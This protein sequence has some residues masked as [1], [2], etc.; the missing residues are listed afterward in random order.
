[1]EKSSNINKLR[2]D[3]LMRISVFLLYYIMMLVLTF[4]LLLLVIGA[5]ILVIFNIEIFLNRIGLVLIALLVASWSFVVKIGFGLL[6]SPFIVTKYER[7]DHIEITEKDCPYLFKI[8]RDV[9]AFTECEMPK[10]VFL[11]S[12][13]NACLFFNTSF[14]NIFIPVKKQLEIGVGLMNGMSTEELKSIIAHEFGHYTQKTGKI[15]GAI[16]RTITVLD[17]MMRNLELPTFL[18][19]L[20]F[21]VYRFVQRGN[22]R[23]S[24]QLE[25]DADSVSCACVGSDVFISAMCKVEI[26]AERQNVYE[27]FVANLLNE[28][29]QCE[30]Y[31]KGYE[32]M[33]PYLEENDTIKLDYRI[34]FSKPFYTPAK[35]P[36]RLK[37]NNIW[38]SH[39]SLEDRI[40]EANKTT[41]VS[42]HNDVAKIDS[43]TLFSDKL[44]QDLGRARLEE[45]KKQNPEQQNIDSITLDQFIEWVENNHNRFLIPPSLVVFLQRDFFSLVDADALNISNDI[46]N[47]DVP[48]NPFTAE[49]QTVIKRYQAAINDLTL[50]QSIQNGKVEVSEFLYNGALYNKKTIPIDKQTEEAESLRPKAAQIDNAMLSYLLSKTDN[51]QFIIR[52]YKMARYTQQIAPKISKLIDIRNEVIAIL[53]NATRNEVDNSVFRELVDNVKMLNVYISS[54][55]RELDYDLLTDVLNSTSISYLSEYSKKS[56][57]S[58]SSIKPNQ[59]NAMSYLVDVLYS[60]HR[61]LYNQCLNSIIYEA[62]KLFPKEEQQALLERIHDQSDFDYGFEQTRLSADFMERVDMKESLIIVLCFLGELISLIALISFIHFSFEAIFS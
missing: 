30:S 44:L 60:I 56:H 10:H 52:Q 51:R 47:S 31:W 20:T 35:I 2:R 55:T 43:K 53:N 13:V 6:R 21:W 57:C 29:K 12:D 41:K 22:L 33:L 3:V 9:A 16:N 7:D 19:E 15:D 34:P 61:D 59:V 32:I 11:S 14:W 54:I 38:A 36:S 45:I 25:Y 39:P 42:S 17:N 5:T 18:K 49:N 8:I 40:N 58:S 24:R 50:L 1:M 48:E 26:L 46:D 23:F 28:N 37:V 4:I 27:T 62:Q